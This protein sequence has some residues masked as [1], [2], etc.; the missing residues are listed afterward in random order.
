MMTHTCVR[1]TC[2]FRG[3]DC[4]LV[5]AQHA[6]ALGL[7]ISCGGAG[8]KAQH[9]ARGIRNSMSSLATWQVGGHLAS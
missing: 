8:L 1:R 6:R 4:R 7:Y 3:W 2:A 9:L 5:P